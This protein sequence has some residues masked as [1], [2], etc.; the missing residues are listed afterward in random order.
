RMSA[1]SASGEGLG[2]A[3]LWLGVLALLGV[4]LWQLVLR[5][6]WQSAGKAPPGWQI[7][8]WPLDPNAVAT[9]AELVRAFEYL[10]LLRLGPGA[11]NQTHR[12]PAAGL[13]QAVAERR[14]AA[15]E[16][17][18]LYAHAR[19]APTDEPLTAADLAVARRS[20]CFL[21]GVAAA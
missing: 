4:L 11:R 9:R 14:R 18:T 17:A 5:A 7:G 16:L 19:Y 13:G 12:A 2:Y 10:A 3:V 15:D 6:A 1:P 21:A 8:P 20:L